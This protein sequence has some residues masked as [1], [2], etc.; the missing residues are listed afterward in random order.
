MISDK[1]F[2]QHGGQETLYTLEGVCQTPYMVQEG[3]SVNARLY[4]AAFSH[5]LETSI[6]FHRFRYMMPPVQ[7]I[8]KPFF[9]F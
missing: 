1:R 6:I 3:R 7:Y 2:V 4:I 5:I 8:P 9:L